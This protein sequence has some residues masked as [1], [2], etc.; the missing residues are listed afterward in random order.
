MLAAEPRGV[1][2]SAKHACWTNYTAVHSKTS[3][4]MS[5]IAMQPALSHVTTQT[6]AELAGLQTCT[7]GR[8]AV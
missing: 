2:N 6:C 1:C 7:V 3:S 8:L 5:F 4:T